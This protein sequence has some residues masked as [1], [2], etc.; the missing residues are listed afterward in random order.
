MTGEQDHELHFEYS[1][2]VRLGFQNAT[3]ETG[4]DRRLGLIASRF[5][6]LPIRL[7]RIDRRPKKASPADDR[8][9]LPELS[10]SDG[11][12]PDEHFTGDRHHRTGWLSAGGGAASAPE[13]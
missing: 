1:S 2:V 13:A 7:R 8:G 3:L 9:E 5:P 6:R 12:C 4:H 10:R 11:Q